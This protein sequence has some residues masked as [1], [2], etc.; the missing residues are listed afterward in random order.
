MGLIISTEKSKLDIDFIHQFLTNAYWAK[1]RTKQE[2]I[3][4]IENCLNFGVYIND[5]QIGFA[6]VL[7][8]Y[9]VFGYL[10]DVFIIEKH[11]GKGY[12]K[13]L[14]KTIMEYPDLQKVH[15][16]MLAT[17]DAHGLYKQFGFDSLPNPNL[18]MGKNDR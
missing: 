4:S 1:G 16:W 2:V 18:V 12:S 6:R 11:R 14:I 8:D 10:M 17:A 15:R 13:I 3:T 9:T 5:E 7:T